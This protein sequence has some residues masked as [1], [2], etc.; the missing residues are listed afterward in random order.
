[1]ENVNKTLYIPLYGKAYVSSRGMILNDPTAEK[2]WETAGFPLKGKAKSKWLA[3][4]MGMRA[5]VFDEWLIEKA[6]QLPD[7]VIVHIGCGLDARCVR[8]E[9]HTNSWFDLDFPDVIA[10]RR[11][12]FEESARYHMISSDIRNPGW[13][14][15]IPGD[16][17]AIILLEGVSMY[18]RYEE[19]VEFL[20]GVKSHF[21]NISVLMDCYTEFAARVSKYKN[22]VNSVGVT[23]LY[24]LDDPHTLPLMYVKEH[25]ITPI[26]LIGL[27]PSGDRK[28]FKTV[29]AGKFAK[30]LYRLYEFSSG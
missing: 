14:E 8:V 9:N 3:Y 4:Y 12:W 29:F 27:L 17:P 30:K 23:S 13:M 21:S 7:A 11:V 24:G 26:T 15:K 19:L 22:P 6:K 20:N 2:I 18:L 25:D 10:E 16:V 5:A 28:L 1:M